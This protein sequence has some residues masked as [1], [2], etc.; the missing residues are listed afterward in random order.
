MPTAGPPSLVLRLFLLA[1][2]PL[3]RLALLVGS[4]SAIVILFFDDDPPPPHHNLLSLL[5]LLLLCLELLARFLLLL[6]TLRGRCRKLRVTRRKAPR[7]VACLVP[8]HEQAGKVVLGLER[9]GRNDAWRSEKR[10]VSCSHWQRKAKAKGHGAKKGAH[11]RPQR[12]RRRAPPTPM[13]LRGAKVAFGVSERRHAVP[14]HRSTGMWATH[15]AARRLLGRPTPRALPTGCAAEGAGT[16]AAAAEAARRKT[17]RTAPTARR[18][19]GAE[20]A[21]RA[22]TGAGSVAAG[23]IPRKPRAPRCFPTLPSRAANRTRPTGARPTPQRPPPP[24]RLSWVGPQA[25]ARTGLGIQGSPARQGS[26]T[27]RSSR[28]PKPARFQGEQRGRIRA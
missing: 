16:R 10:R 4:S 15:I 24:R 27:L 12:G 6:R 28:V 1:W 17:R 7:G 19:T 13:G 23:R 2:Q 11:S 14:C 20:A 5:I 8:C 26:D 3:L 25:S 22:A 9:A 18:G 21:A